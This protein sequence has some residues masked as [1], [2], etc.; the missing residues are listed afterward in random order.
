MPDQEY[1]SVL[2]WIDE[3]Y[4]PGVKACT[5]RIQEWYE[6]RYQIEEFLGAGHTSVVFKATDTRLDR[7]AA[8]KM[9]QTRDL[10]LNSAILLREVKVL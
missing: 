1:R 4:H 5:V 3:V 7:I 2:H 8:L 10:D 6:S 9:W